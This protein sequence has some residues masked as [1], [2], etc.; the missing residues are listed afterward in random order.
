MVETTT[1][2]W[3]NNL[4]RI[5]QFESIRQRVHQPHTFSLV[6]RKCDSLRI[7]FLFL[8]SCNPTVKDTS[9]ITPMTETSLEA[10]LRRLGNLESEQERY[11]GLMEL[12]HLLQNQEGFETVQ[13][14]LD[15]LLPIIDMWVNGLEK[16]WVPGDQESAGEDG[17]LGGFFIMRVFP[18]QTDNSIHHPYRLL[19]CFRCGRCTAGVC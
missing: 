18:G 3:W 12:N 16:Y 15:A 11:Q 7:M 10:E 17:Y 8:L 6:D 13:A 2:N 5:Q 9:S 19:H 4:I 14:D 1:L